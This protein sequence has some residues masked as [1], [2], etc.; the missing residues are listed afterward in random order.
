MRMCL[1]SRP[2]ESLLLKQIHVAAGYLMALNL[3]WRFAWAFIGNRYARWRAILPGGAGYW[4][5]LRAY[6]AAF[7]SGEPQEYVGHNPA[8]R[9]AIATLFFCWLFRSRLDLFS[10]A[11]TCSG[12]PSAR[13]LPAGLGGRGRSGNRVAAR[14]D[15]GRSGGIPSDARL[16]ASD[17]DEPPLCFLCTRGRHCAASGGSDRDRAARGWRHYLGDVHGPED[18]IGGRLTYR[19][20]P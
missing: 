15:Y 3:I 11:P 1:A 20:G 4:G 14:L 19:R 6:V 12:R 17:R 5:A 8:A 13:G 2:A 9:L 18:L 7:L 10:P 16:P